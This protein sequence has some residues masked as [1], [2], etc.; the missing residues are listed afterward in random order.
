[1]GIENLLAKEK[2]Q[3]GKLVAVKLSPSLISQIQAIRK[4]TKKTNA[5]VYSALLS[6]GLAAYK[7]AIAGNNGKR[8]KV[9]PASKAGKV[10]RKK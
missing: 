2:P 10:T 5:E 7:T 3:D 8:K 6:E 1:M 9:V 4:S